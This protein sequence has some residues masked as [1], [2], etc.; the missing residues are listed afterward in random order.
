MPVAISDQRSQIIEGQ[1]AFQIAQRLDLHMPEARRDQFRH[2][3]EYLADCVSTPVS[4]W[5]LG[6]ASIVPR[7]LASA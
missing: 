6:L 3:A 7:A 4:V 2:P 5:P 1:R